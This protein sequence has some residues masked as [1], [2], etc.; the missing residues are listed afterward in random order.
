M[1]VKTPGSVSLKFAV[2]EYIIEQIP[3][4]LKK[5]ETA[6]RQTEEGKRLRITDSKTRKEEAIVQVIEYLTSGTLEPID[7]STPKA[8]IK[9]LYELID[10]YDLSVAL[11]ITELEEAIVNH[12]TVCDDLDSQTFIRFAREC[13]N[14]NKDRLIAEGSMLGQFIKHN[15]ARRLDVLVST[16]AVDSIKNAGGILCKQL[17]EVLAEKYLEVI[18]QQKKLPAHSHG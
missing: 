13:Y 18:R 17:L 8:C 4:Y 15:L 14:G 9:R 11:D 5:L 12:I 3:E 16:G 2:A 7:M 10:L 6:K 1:T